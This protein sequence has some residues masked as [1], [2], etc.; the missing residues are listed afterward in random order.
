MRETGP[1][2]PRFWYFFI[3]YDSYDPVVTSRDCYKFVDIRESR[4][5]RRKKHGSGG[6]EHFQHMRLCLSW[7]SESR[8]VLL[9]A[10]KLSSE[11]FG[12]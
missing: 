1:N 3:H 8:I 11:A 2:W 4:D 9:P 12:F 6:P 5:S 10:Q 7:K